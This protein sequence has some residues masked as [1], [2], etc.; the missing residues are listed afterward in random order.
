MTWTKVTN[1]TK[2]WKGT[3]KIFDR[4]NLIICIDFCFISH[5]AGLTQK[6]LM[7]SFNAQRTPNK[8][9]SVNI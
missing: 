9:K 5:I 3:R 1:G 6:Y 7:I 4:K 8:V 2:I